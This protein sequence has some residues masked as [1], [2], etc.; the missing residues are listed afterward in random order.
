MSLKIPKIFIFLVNNDIGHLL[1]TSR[2]YFGPNK[3]RKVINNIFIVLSYK[4]YEKF[5]L[6]F[7]IILNSPVVA[8][9]CRFMGLIL[10]P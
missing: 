2:E 6:E 8:K 10:V 5:V 9:L 7:L 4:F 1:E 3:F